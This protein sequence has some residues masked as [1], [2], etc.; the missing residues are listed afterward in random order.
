MRWL[1]KRWWFLVGLGFV[2]VAL[3]A[4]YLLIPIDEGPISQAA[5]DKI[6]LGMSEEQVQ[7]MLGPRTI[8]VTCVWDED[9]KAGR[10]T[11]IGWGDEDGNIISVNF[12]ATNRVT[13]KG[14][15]RT[16]L[17][18]LELMTRHIARRMPALWP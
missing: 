11:E 18:F 17:S 13:A 2:L 6:Q 5:C 9:A 15:R 4:G 14:F 16:D 12:G 1:L 3:V 10:I 8:S 7:E